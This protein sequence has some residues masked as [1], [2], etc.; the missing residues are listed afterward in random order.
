MNYQTKSTRETEPVR[1]KPFL[2]PVVLFMLILGFLVIGLSLDPKLVP[3]PL[4]GRSI[5]PFSLSLLKDSER[6]VTLSEL[7]S[8]VFLLNVWASWCAACR[9]EHPLLLEIAKKGEIKLIGLN[10]KDQRDNSKTWLSTFGDPYEFS[11]YDQK[12]KFGIDLGV[13]GVPETF[14]IDRNGIILYKHVGPIDEKLYRET[15]LSLKP[16]GNE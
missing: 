9:Q 11:L 4:V 1:R 2:I 8:E 13:Y 6:I 5:P 12:G 10:Y 3:S 14:L 16:I 7:P 15:L